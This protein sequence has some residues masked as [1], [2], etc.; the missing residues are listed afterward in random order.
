MTSLKTTP[1]AEAGTE[2]RFGTKKRTHT[3]GQLRRSDAGSRVVLCG[4]VD[5]RRDHGSLV[6]VDLRDRYGKTQVN[7]DLAGLDAESKAAAEALRAEFVVRIEGEVVERPGEARNQKVVTG[8]IEVQARAVQ[9]LNRCVT[10][11]IDVSATA[12]EGDAVDPERRYTHRLFDLRRPVMQ[13]RLLTRHKVV[14]AARNYLDLNGFI[15]VET[16]ILT[17]ST[18]EGARDFLVPS[19]VHAGRFFALPQSPQLFK[20]MLMVAGYDRYYQIARCFRDEDLRA[21]RQLEFT[22]IDLEMSFIEEEDIYANFEGL[23]CSMWKEVLGK[24]LKRPFR[25]MAYEEAVLRYGIDK[26]DLRFGLEIEDVTAIAARSGATF[27]KDAANS[28]ERKGGAV[29]G[30]RVPGGAEKF[31]RKELDALPDVVKEK[32][33][34][35]VAWIKVEAAGKITGSIAKF[36]E[37]E[38]AA[39]LL[40]AFK[41]EAGD[42]ILIVADK[43]K[44]IAAAGLGQLRLFVGKKLD[45]VDKKRDEFLWVTSFPFFEHDPETNTYI[46]CRHP[47]TR[48]KDADIPFLEKEPLKVHTQAYDLVLNGWELGSGSIRNH[49]TELQERVFSILG[50]SKEQAQHRFG[51]LL[52]ALKSGAPPHGGAAFGVDRICALVQ[53]LD[54]LR[55]VIAFPK[56]SKATDLLTEAPN[57]VEAAQLKMLHIQLLQPPPEAPPR[58]G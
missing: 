11:P 55:E 3:C 58:A 17:R 21:D 33:A 39:D 5:R 54:N 56:T 12:A 4:W 14:L 47:F 57:T 53:G 23:F 51:F 18:P 43:N 50:Y 38:V 1:A 28:T 42:L 16:P 2:N 8:E 10:P 20:Q 30:I 34:K 22:Q 52:E 48:P 27:L 15:E 13:Q 26:P 36:F 24:E 31:T 46:A 41:A 7:L 45:L 37:G 6:F 25:R 35:G 9:I 49:D 40:R 44:D 19:R 29:R 32:G